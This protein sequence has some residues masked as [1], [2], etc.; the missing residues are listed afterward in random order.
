MLFVIETSGNPKPMRIVVLTLVFGTAF[1]MVGCDPVKEE[2]LVDF[3]TVEEKAVEE[4]KDPS[5]GESP[6][7]LVETGLSET[8]SSSKPFS[9]WKEVIQSCEQC[10]VNLE[11]EREEGTGQGTG[12]FIRKD[13]LVAT[14]FHV[15]DGAMV[16]KAQNYQGFR[17]S[18]EGILAVDEARDLAIIKFAAKDLPVL[19]LS[20]KSLPEKGEEILAIGNPFGLDTSVTRGI[21]SALRNE[22]DAQVIQFDAAVSPGSSGSPLLNNSGEVL[23]VVTSVIASRQGHNFAI[24]SS[25]LAEL[26]DAAT[27]LEVVEIANYFKKPEPILPSYNDVALPSA[28]ALMEE[29]E[30]L[31]VEAYS[32][33]E[34]ELKVDE[35]NLF[36]DSYWSSFQKPTGSSWALMFVDGCDYQY[37]TE[38]KASRAEIAKGAFE[39]KA[40]YPKRIY[41]LLSGPKVV[42]LKDPNRIGFDFDYEYFYANDSKLVGGISRTELAL[43]WIGEKW[44]VDKFRETVEA[45]DNPERLLDSYKSTR[46]VTSPVAK[47]ASLKKGQRGYM[48]THEGDALIW[49]NSFQPGDQALWNG[50]V[51]SEGYARGFGRLSWYKNGRFQYSYTGNMR[52][53][54]L[55]GSVDT[56]DSVGH[57]GS[58]A[59]RGGKKAGTWRYT[60][61]D[62]S[63]SWTKKYN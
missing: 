32:E 27:A 7:T 57:T 33:T 22:D 42:D 45:Y 5:I 25:H 58:G 50:D 35:L 37:K 20:S 63:R 8:D 40:K 10:V 2:A 46:E 9:N 36:W 56:V 3:E 15:I 1:L 60:S 12:F 52:R 49:N 55:D 30:G 4:I 38:G 19:P 44:F 28:E 29:K 48:L 41:N 31:D 62:G 23:G 17:L 51:D 54:K 26:L 18:V 21:V 11:V 53:G 34:V 43:S 14:N 39:L 13:G 61:Q 59:Y 47:V 16:I 24:A 6:E